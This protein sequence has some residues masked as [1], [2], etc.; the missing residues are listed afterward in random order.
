MQVSAVPQLAGPTHSSPVWHVPPPQIPPLPHS[1]LVVQVLLVQDAVEQTLFVL[2]PQSAFEPQGTEVHLALLQSAP[3][4][5]CESLAQIAVLLHLAPLHNLLTAQALSPAQLA[6]VHFAA[7]H[8]PLTAQLASSPQLFAL[9]F[10]LLQ[11]E[12]DD[13]QSVSTEHC[14]AAPQVMPVPQKAFVVQ[15]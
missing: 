9:H 13:A 15:I 1:L 7:L 5:H 12:P 6:A 4:G 2:V 14:D 10:T 3:V 11:T 8:T